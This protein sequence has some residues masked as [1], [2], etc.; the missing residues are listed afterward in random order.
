MIP[1]NVVVTLPDQDGYLRPS[2]LPASLP[3]PMSIPL[4]AQLVTG[5][6]HPHP[7][8]RKGS[9]AIWALNNSFAR[10][11]SVKSSFSPH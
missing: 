1:L 2:E 3:F 4:P 7:S 8:K 9:L 6:T 5:V 11:A 10:R